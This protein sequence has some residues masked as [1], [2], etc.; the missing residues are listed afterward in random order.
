ME[1]FGYFVKIERPAFFGLGL[2]R[3]HLEIFRIN[4]GKYLDMFVPLR[5][6]SFYTTIVYDHLWCLYLLQDHPCS[7]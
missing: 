5:R 7:R 3:K 6:A 1:L 4:S 2:G